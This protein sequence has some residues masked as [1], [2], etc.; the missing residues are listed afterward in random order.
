MS[1]I[2]SPNS[3]ESR[4]FP[5]VIEN[6]IGLIL[7]IYIFKAVTYWGA[8]QFTPVQTS[9]PIEKKLLN[10]DERWPLA[11]RDGKCYVWSKQL[12]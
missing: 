12:G 10:R 5:P 6:M 9:F 11:P 4:Y 7:N 1:D 2:F 8:L 3:P